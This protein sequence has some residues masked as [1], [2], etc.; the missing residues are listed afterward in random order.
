MV[1]LKSLLS[2]GLAA[3]LTM[4]APSWPPKPGCGDLDI[5]FT[6]LPPYHPLV[7]A[8]GFDSAAVDA[9]LRGDAADIVKAGYNLRVVLMG[10]EQPLSVL[11]GQMDGINWD[12]TGV[13]YGVRGSRL[14]NLTLRFAVL[15]LPSL[16]LFSAPQYGGD[17]IVIEE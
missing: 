17:A 15:A 3:S 2:L 9:A 13:G 14:V 11:S 7:T 5:I 12:G 4:A 16:L 8:Q 6:G 10:P 1:I